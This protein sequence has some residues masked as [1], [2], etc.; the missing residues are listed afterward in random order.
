[1]I[2]SSSEHAKDYV[3]LW[4][5]E[6]RSYVVYQVYHMALS[7]K[8]R[9]CVVFEQVI[10]LVTIDTNQLACSL[11]CNPMKMIK[12]WSCF[13]SFDCLLCVRKCSSRS[14]KMTSLGNFRGFCLHFTYAIWAQRSCHWVK[15]KVWVPL[16][17]DWT[18]NRFPLSKDR[19]RRWP[20][21]TPMAKNI[22][23][24]F[25]AAYVCGLREKFLI[26]FRIC[27]TKTFVE[28]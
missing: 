24:Q 27:G 22:D 28:S 2:L 18:W 3:A 19:T 13:A 1:M 23:V 8:N 25:A 16:L 5:I 26:P 12:G 11:Y 7:L 17:T 20:I 21:L 4:H 15:G 9:R 14:T 6:L 10:L